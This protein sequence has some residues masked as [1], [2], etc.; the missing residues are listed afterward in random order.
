M[1]AGS[2]EEFGEGGDALLTGGA[3]IGPTDTGGQQGGDLVAEVGGVVGGDAGVDGGVAVGICGDGEVLVVVGELGAHLF[4]EVGIEVDDEGVEL[5]AQG[6]IGDPAGGEVDG[7]G[8]GTVAIRAGG[9]DGE[10]VGDGGRTVE[11]VAAGEEPGVD[12]RK[13]QEQG[14]QFDPPSGHRSGHP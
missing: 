1:G 8:L 13:L 11:A 7:D 12:A 2:A 5:I 4:G 6:G 14:G 3:G 9:Q 10:G